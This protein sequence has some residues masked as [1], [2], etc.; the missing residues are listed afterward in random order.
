MYNRKR[1]DQRRL[2]RLY[3]Q[4]CLNTRKWVLYG[5]YY[6]E[7]KGYYV[8]IDRGTNTKKIKHVHNRRVRRILNREMDHLSNKGRYRRKS[9]L[10]WDLD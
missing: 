10:W 8:R 1:E 6:D 9:D 5:A 3:G 2:K 7:D 4:C